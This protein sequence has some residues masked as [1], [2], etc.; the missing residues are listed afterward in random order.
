MNVRS[1]PAI[2]Q[3]RFEKDFG[4]EI[5]PYT[6]SQPEPPEVHIFLNDL[7]Q[8]VKQVR[9]AIKAPIPGPATPL[10]D[11]AAE[12]GTW[13]QAVR[14]ELTERQRRNT[15]TLEMLATLDQGTIKQRVLVRCIGGKIAAGDVAELDAVLDRKTPQG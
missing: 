10:E 6:P 11:L 7:M 1:V 2:K 15:R 14:Y 12:V 5:I 9:E 3:K 4:L 8:Q 13:L